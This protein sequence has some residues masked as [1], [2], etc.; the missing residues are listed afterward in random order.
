MGL[1]NQSLRYQY[2]VA[3]KG[4]WKFFVVNPNG[5]PLDGYDEQQNDVIWSVIVL[6]Y[7]IWNCCSP[8]QQLVMHAITQWVSVYIWPNMHKKLPNTLWVFAGNPSKNNHYHKKFQ[9][10]YSL[11]FFSIWLNDPKKVYSFAAK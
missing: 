6:I 10:P 11:F 8:W 9:M 4:P 7:L 2:V 5:K 3:H 1:Q